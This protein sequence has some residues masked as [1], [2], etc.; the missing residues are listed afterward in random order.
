MVKFGDLENYK[1]IYELLPLWE[2]FRIILIE[3]K[4]N[5]GHWVCITR[6]NND[7]VFSTLM[8][9]VIFKI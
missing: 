4:L 6:I 8:V 7:F 1:D 2:D 9:I 5:S 3:Q